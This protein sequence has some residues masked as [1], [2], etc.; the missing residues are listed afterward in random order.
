LIL[1]G[2]LLG[3]KV[4]KKLNQDKFE[5]FALYSTLIAGLLLFVPR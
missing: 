1:L 5:K 2:G 3:Q 4:I